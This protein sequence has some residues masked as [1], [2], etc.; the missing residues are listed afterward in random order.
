MDR[1]VTNN[2]MP[3]EI[4]TKLAEMQAAIKREIGLTPEALLFAKK[5]GNGGG[6]GGNGGRGGKSP[7]RD[8]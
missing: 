6:N 2:A 3:D 5:G 7:R 8:K 4:I 1:K